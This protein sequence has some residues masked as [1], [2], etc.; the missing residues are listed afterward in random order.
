MF[1]SLTGDSDLPRHAQPP[2]K[3][4]A[5][6]LSKLKF[7]PEFQ[8]K[9][10]ALREVLYKHGTLLGLELDNNTNAQ[11]SIAH[12]SSRRHRIYPDLGSPS[13]A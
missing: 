4:D 1:R 11:R 6:F 13:P 7:P 10:T 3:R 5:R 12:P 8:Q 9:Q 2:F